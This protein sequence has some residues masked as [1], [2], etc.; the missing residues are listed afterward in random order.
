M[1]R[2]LL[3]TLFVESLA[4]A[5]CEGMFKGLGWKFDPSIKLPPRV[6][7]SKVEDNPPGFLHGEGSDLENKTI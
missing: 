6:L 3:D 5:F 1:T 2:P 7:E 4:I